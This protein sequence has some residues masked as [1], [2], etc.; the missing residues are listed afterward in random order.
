M[1]LKAVFVRNAIFDPSKGNWSVAFNASQVW[2][3]MGA[4]GK[5]ATL[6]TMQKAQKVKQEHN[7][8]SGIFWQWVTRCLTEEMDGYRSNG[9]FPPLLPSRVVL[10]TTIARHCSAVKVTPS[11][12]GIFAK[13]TSVFQC[14][15]LPDWPLGLPVVAQKLEQPERRYR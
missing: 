2:L 11:T 15:Q 7:F 4:L 8:T 5:N 9:H 6:Y 13:D 14:P 3:R 12:D 10:H 1:L